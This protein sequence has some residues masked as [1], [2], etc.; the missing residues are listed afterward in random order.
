VH[1]SEALIIHFTDA[2]MISLEAGSNAGDLVNDENGLHPEDFHV[3]LIVHWVPE[4]PR[5]MQKPQ[6]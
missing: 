6:P 3:S 2:S 5:G 4:L 1:E